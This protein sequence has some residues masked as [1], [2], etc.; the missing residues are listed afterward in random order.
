MRLDWDVINVGKINDILKICPKIG[1][2][3]AIDFLPIAQTQPILQ[4]V[5]DITSISG[6]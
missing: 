3:P 4:Y 1:E 2:I 6:A 5:L